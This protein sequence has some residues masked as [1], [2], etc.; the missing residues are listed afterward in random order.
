[1]SLDL[2]TRVSVTLALDLFKSEAGS[3]ARALLGGASALPAVKVAIMEGGNT[4]PP[5]QLIPD[6]EQILLIGMEGLEEEI[7]LIPLRIDPAPPFVTREESGTYVTASVGLTRRPLEYVLAA[8][9]IIV[10][11]RHS[12]ENV[13]DPGL[14]WNS[15]EES[16]PNQF[17]DTVR[18]RELSEDA[19][20]ASKIFYSC[21]PLSRGKKA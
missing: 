6:S 15:R 14:A 8:A 4:L 7:L 2:T 13:I 11:A 20:A 5:P 19:S 9:V 16:A 1:M 21:L 17:F 3:V 12:S 18:L 10:L